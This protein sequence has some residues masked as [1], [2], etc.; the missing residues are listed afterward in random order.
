MRYSIVILL[1]ISMIAMPLYVLGASEDCCGPAGS[2]VAM[3]IGEG[4]MAMGDECCCL[5]M[6]MLGQT[7]QSGDSDQ[8]ND[9]FGP[10]DDGSCPS[11]CCAGVT[12]TM[13]SLSGPVRLVPAPMCMDALNV[14]PQRAL[15]QPHLQRLKR[16]PRVV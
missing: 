5:P 6:D 10:C 11:S 2:A 8:E 16:P 9:P 4:S 15:P 12:Q 3:T 7:G 1:A 14:Q 13:L